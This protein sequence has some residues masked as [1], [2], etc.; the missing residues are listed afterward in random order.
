MSSNVRIL[1]QPEK[2]FRF[3]Y[4][5]EK[6][7]NVSIAGISTNDEIH[8]YPTIMVRNYTGPVCVFISCVTYTMP[9]RYLIS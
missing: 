3:R 7:L 4:D 9:Y 1:E 8:T 2:S 6:R 5:S